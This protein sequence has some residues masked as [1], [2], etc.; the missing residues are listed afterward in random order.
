M[1]YDRIPENLR[2]KIFEVEYN[3]DTINEMK[4]RVEECREYYNMLQDSLN[5]VTV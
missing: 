2:V 5:K 1:Q 3:E 4:Q